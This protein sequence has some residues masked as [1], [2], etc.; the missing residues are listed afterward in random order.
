MNLSDS[1]QSLFQ[2]LFSMFSDFVSKLDSIYIWQGVSILRFWLAISIL[3]AVSAIVLISVKDSS[4]IV[5]SSDRQ[6][7]YKKNE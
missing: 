7:N 2:F 4:F 6:N 3:G 5:V 1:F